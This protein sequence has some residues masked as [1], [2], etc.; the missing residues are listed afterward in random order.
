M[1]VCLFSLGDHTGDL[2]LCPGAVVGQCPVFSPMLLQLRMK[3]GA[4]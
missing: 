3:H 4:L 1:C 2:S